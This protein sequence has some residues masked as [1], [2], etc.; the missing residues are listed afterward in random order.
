MT[1]YFCKKHRQIIQSQGHH[2]QSPKSSVTNHPKAP[3]PSPR[4]S[5]NSR[6]ICSTHISPKNRPP[7]NCSKIRKIGGEMNV[8]RS[9]VAPK[10]IRL[11]HF[12]CAVSQMRKSLF[13]FPKSS[14]G[15][16]IFRFSGH[17]RHFSDKLS[18]A[19][20]PRAISR[21]R[22]SRGAIVAAPTEML[23]ARF[24]WCGGSSGTSRK[25][26]SRS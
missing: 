15:R 1:P 6:K 26:R 18:I 2:S 16:G 14:G 9:S 3:P 8:P 21:R 19:R 5:K 7:E 13:L 12:L 17:G 25:S 23:R 11:T 20:A 4:M 10:K 22:A 24:S